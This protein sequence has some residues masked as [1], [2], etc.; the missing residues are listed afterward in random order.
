VISSCMHRCARFHVKHRQQLADSQS[1]IP[2]TPGQERRERGT[3]GAWRRIWLNVYIHKVIHSDIHRFGCADHLG[4]SRSGEETAAPAEL[5]RHV[6][7]NR[8]DRSGLDT[9]SP[10][11]PWPHCIPLA[12]SVSSPRASV[13]RPTHSVRRLSCFR[14]FGTLDS[15]PIPIAC[16]VTSNPVNIAQSVHLSTPNYVDLFPAG[17]P[18]HTLPLTLSG[19]RGIAAHS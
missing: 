12:A 17:L 13:P 19:A 9:V 3:G 5:P 8:Q 18:D 10:S 2:V 6:S 15:T 7:H 14:H 16:A 1:V 11:H 4:K